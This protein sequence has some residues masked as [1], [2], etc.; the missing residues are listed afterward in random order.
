MAFPIS[1]EMIEGNIKNNAYLVQEEEVQLPVH[2][3]FRQ[4]WCNQPLNEWP[5]HKFEVFIEECDKWNADYQLAQAKRLQRDETAQQ[6]K[7]K[8]WNDCA[9]AFDV[10]GNPNL[11][12][13]ETRVMQLAKRSSFQSWF[14]M[15]RFLVP[16]IR[17]IP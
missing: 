4:V 5:D 10:V 7:R 3:R 14:D 8:F 2:P 9:E 6:L 1:I 12:V 17:Q 11:H 16:L 13:L 15:Y